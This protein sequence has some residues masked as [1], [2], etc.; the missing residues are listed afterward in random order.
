[1][2]NYL[3]FIKKLFAWRSFII[4]LLARR[5]RNTPT[6]SKSAH[7]VTTP[8]HASNAA[9]PLRP[10]PILWT[11]SNRYWIDWSGQVAL[12]LCCHHW[13]IASQYINFLMTT[14]YVSHHQRQAAEKLDF[15]HSE[16]FDWYLHAVKRTCSLNKNEGTGET[17]PPARTYYPQNCLG[18]RINLEPVF[19]GN[20]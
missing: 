1:M 11:I 16:K 18:G 12:I 13:I 8:S 4:S 17:K 15:V 3:W 20:R 10:W 6:R 9:G 14:N 7:A 2:W 5:A 19:S